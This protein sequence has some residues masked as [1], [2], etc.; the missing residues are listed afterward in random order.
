[1]STPFLTYCPISDC[2]YTRTTFLASNRQQRTYPLL[3]GLEMVLAR[4]RGGGGRRLRRRHGSPAP[5][6]PARPKPRRDL[7][8]PESPAAAD[9]IEPR[10]GGARS[11]DGVGWASGLGDLGCALRS[12]Q[13]PLAPERLGLRLASSAAIFFFFRCVGVESDRSEF[14]HAVASSRSGSLVLGL[15]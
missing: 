3:P 13:I 8:V 12:F 15:V 2:G 7:S 5:T 14:L 4:R 9:P 11:G 1:M 6:S 10:G